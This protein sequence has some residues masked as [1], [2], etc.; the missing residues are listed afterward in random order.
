LRFFFPFCSSLAPQAEQRVALLLA[1]HFACP[2]PIA[3][4]DNILARK[5]DNRLSTSASISRKVAVGCCCRHSAIPLR[6]SSLNPLHLLRISS[7]FMP[8]PLFPL[9]LT[10]FPEN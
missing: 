5:T 7:P 10:P 4:S 9:Y 2:L 3:A 8:P 6:I 1:S